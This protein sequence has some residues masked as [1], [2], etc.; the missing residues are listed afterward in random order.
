MNDGPTHIDSTEPPLPNPEVLVIESARPGSSSRLQTAAQALFRSQ[1]SA[2]PSLNLIIV[3][4][5]W[6]VHGSE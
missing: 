5:R 3:E 1:R 6:L 2:P 4:R